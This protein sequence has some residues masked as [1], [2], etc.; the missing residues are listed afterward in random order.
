MLPYLMVY[1][2]GGI[3][4]YVYVKHRCNLFYPEHT[5]KWLFLTS[6]KF[7]QGYFAK[8]IRDAHNLCKKYE[9]DTQLSEIEQEVYY[10]AQIVEV[11]QWLFLWWLIL[12]E[13]TEM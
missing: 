7:D 5:K 13:L 12:L 10:V 2:V 6:I 9:I 8:W 11:L 1:V 4:T 3:I